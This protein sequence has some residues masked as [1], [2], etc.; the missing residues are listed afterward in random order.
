[1]LDPLLGLMLR[2]VGTKSLNGELHLELFSYGR[3][4]EAVLMVHALF[5]FI[6]TS[7]N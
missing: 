7:K 6:D 2:G 4:F 1:M 3:N 5:L